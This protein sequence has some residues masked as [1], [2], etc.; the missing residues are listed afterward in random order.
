MGTLAVLT[1]KGRA[2]VADSEAAVEIFCRARPDFTIRVT[3]Q[4]M[5]ATVDGM[6]Y[7]GNCLEAVLEIKTRDMTTEQLR[8]WHNEWLVTF[9]KIIEARNIAKALCVPLVGFLYLKPERRLM[10]R[11]ICG[12]SGLFTTKLRV[13]T[14]ETQATVN[15]GR[16]VRSNAFLDMTGCKVF[17]AEAPK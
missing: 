8:A 16:A 9:D 1:P 7:R 10:V 13:E 11:R 15:G 3:D 14:T 5:P 17:D 12:P 6:M 2:A 4:S